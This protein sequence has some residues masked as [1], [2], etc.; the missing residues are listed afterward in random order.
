MET[1]S[2]GLACFEPQ[3]F[4]DLVRLGEMAAR[5][6]LF[7]VQSPETAVVM[8]LTGASLGLPPVTA[9]RGIH[10]LQGRAVL[11]SDLLVAVVL[12][13]G[14][15]DYW[16][17][18]EV[19]AERC[20]IETRRRGHAEPIR[21]TWTIEMARKAT[22]AGKGTWQQFPAAMLRA[23]C[24]AELARMVYPDVLFG[25]YVEGEIEDEHRTH[26]AEP[27]TP[28]SFAALDASAQ[29]VRGGESRAQVMQRPA[30]ENPASAPEIEA[31]REFVVLSPE[32]ENRV[33]IAEEVNDL[34]AQASR[35]DSL[36]ALAGLWV[37]A[38]RD[39]SAWDD[40]DAQERAWS[41]F[42]ARAKDLGATVAALKAAVAKLD[43]PPDGPGGGSPKPAAPTSTD[44]QGSAES[45][46]ANDGAQARHPDAW[47]MT[48]EGITAH[49]ATLESR[50]VEASGRRHLDQIADVLLTHAIHEY[51]T[52]LRVLSRHVE[53]DDHGERR[54]SEIPHDECIARVET[55]L[56]EGPRARVLPMPKRPTAPTQRAAGV[57]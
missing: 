32:Q 45:T 28:E 31:P 23:R 16:R 26:A 14:Q 41:A 40:R 9:L 11:S 3:S 35:A 13:S 33:R 22:L 27:V 42:K 21:H 5:S 47:R 10:V 43:T 2:T 30:L 4:A 6:R 38:K 49:V 24:S 48:R 57:R 52:R 53:T 1:R 19:T 36:S 18:V 34:R 54:T 20:V 46:A 39:V 55:W 50:H 29:A 17:P 37:A 15:C 51:A 44:A 56:R 25:V 12:R 7:A 8:M